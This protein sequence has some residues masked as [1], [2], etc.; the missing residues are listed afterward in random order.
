[1]TRAGP[2][3]FSRRAW[4][5]GVA[6][7]G[8]GVAGARSLEAA[9][10]AGALVGVA[11]GTTMAAA[12][13]T[14]V[15]LAGGLAF[16]QPGQT[17]LV[18]PNL[19]CPHPHPATT[20][21]EVLSAVLELVRERG[22]GRLI[23]GDQTFYVQSTVA[24]VRRAGLEA[25]V[26]S[27][28]AEFVAFDDLPRRPL[29]PPAARHWPEGYRI[30]AMLDQV[31]HVI[32][33]ACV[34]THV[35]ARYTMAMKN[36]IG[37]IDADS[38]RYYHRI[39]AEQGYDAFAALIAE[40]SLA[41]R[42]SLHILDGT[43]AFVAGGPSDGRVVHPRLVIASRDLLATDVTGLA[44]LRHHGTDAVIQDH[45]PWTQPKIRYGMALGLGVTGPEEIDVRAEGIEETAAIRRL[46]A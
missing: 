45:S 22:V 10:P 25:A 43:A 32:N 2:D 34:K 35:L 18:K 19:C 41:I 42:P 8:I 44:V 20:S 5:A 6:G 16:I 38:R 14:A 12:T 29:R 26:R 31:D 33:L 17:V 13:R 1:M 11:R 9:R 40:M 36:A 46:M 39:R 28:G 37:V 7:L 30:P 24:N 21:P 3:R 15:R 4:L 23:V 27:R